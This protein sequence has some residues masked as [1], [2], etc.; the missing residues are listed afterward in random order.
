[1]KDVILNITSETQ[2]K[3]VSDFKRFCERYVERFFDIFNIMEHQEDKHSTGMYGCTDIAIIEI[4]NMLDMK[5]LIYVDFSDNNNKQVVLTE[6]IN[7]SDTEIIATYCINN[8]TLE[9]YK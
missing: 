7:D 9:V 5:Y 8:N 1:M 2:D 3:V 6:K 4:S